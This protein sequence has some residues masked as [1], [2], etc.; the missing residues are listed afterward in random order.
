MVGLSGYQVT[1]SEE[2]P[3]SFIT[4]ENTLDTTVTYEITEN[5]TYYVY[6]K[7]A[8]NHISHEKIVIDK[9]DNIP[10]YITSVTNSSNETWTNKDV[11]VSLLAG[12]KET[13]V[14]KYQMKYSKTNNE[15]QDLESNSYTFTEELNE[16]V[17]FRVQDE[18]GNISEEASTDIKIDK[19]SP[20]IPSIA[21]SSNGYW[22]NQ[23][24]TIALSST[25]AASGILKYQVKHSGTNS[26][27]TDLSSSSDNWYDERNEVV[28]YR[29]MDNA[30]NVSEEA[31]TNIK[32]DKTVQ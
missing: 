12:D 21:N 20:T 9:I 19:T 16:T 25:D 5:G 26:A 11:T 28:S 10:P 2:E 23:T 24:I 30:G 4:I 6:A 15:W 31:S 17:Y 22:T 18:V 1:T 8:Y 29:A 3:T 32:I 13:R 7:D 14:T 27:W